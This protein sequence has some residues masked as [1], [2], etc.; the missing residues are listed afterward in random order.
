M[1][2]SGREHTPKSKPEANVMDTTYLWKFLGNK[3]GEV[4]LGKM[5]NMWRDA[6]VS[7]DAVFFPT[8][9]ITIAEELTTLI[10]P[11]F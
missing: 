5:E 7:P 11:E 6:Q 4:E 2:S 9:R 8:P 1:K 10:A 3:V